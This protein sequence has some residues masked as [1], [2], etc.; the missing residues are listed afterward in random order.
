MAS[1][2]SKS[3]IKVSLEGDPKG[4]INAAT[5]AQHAINKLT[6]E[7]GVSRQEATAFVNNFDK[8]ER[9]K[10]FQQLQDSLKKNQTALAAAKQRARELAAEY[11]KTGDATAKLGAEGSRERVQRLSAEI[12]QQTTA[13]RTEGDALRKLGIDTKDLSGSQKKLTAEINKQEHNWKAAAEAVKRNAAMEKQAAE[14]RKLASA[15]TEKRIA[16]EKRYQEYVE[17]T[18][19]KLK[20][21]RSQTDKNSE[22]F[23][24]YKL[25]VVG[26]AAAFTATF[27]PLKQFVSYM[28]ENI[29]YANVQ[30]E[31]EAK[32][33][34]V[35][36]ATGNAAGLTA[37]EIKSYAGELQGLT[38]YGDEG[39]I[40][41]AALLATFKSIKGDQFKETIALAQDLSTIMGGDL[42]S[43]ALQLGKA[44]EDPV[45][46]LTALRRSGVSFTAEQKEQIAV[47]VETGRQQEAQAL[48]LA[49]VREQVGGAAA[50]MRD[51]YGGAVIA[52]GNAWGDLKEELGFFITKNDEAIRSVNFTEQA[53][54]GLAG[55]IK[56]FRENHE[57]LITSVIKF[58]REN[59]GLIAGVGAAGAA[60]TTA[61]VAISLY[62]TALVAS[63]VAS[64]QA[65]AA[66]AAPLAVI[67]GSVVT[68]GYAVKAYMEMR[69]AQE[70]AAES[71][72][73]AEEQEAKYQDRL[74]RASKAAGKQLKS[75]Q[76]VQEAYRQGVI[77]YDRLTD[78]YSK[79]S[80][81]AR[82]AAEDSKKA[83]EEQ[84]KVFEFTAISAEK[85]VDKTKLSAEEQ[86][87][88]LAE[89]KREYQSLVREIESVDQQLTK[90]ADEGAA[91]QLKLANASR[92]PLEAWKA[93]RQAAL[94]LG[95]AMAAAKKEADKLAA[96]GDIE[97][98]NK[99]YA[100]AVALGQQM[101]D[102][103]KELA[104]EVKGNFTPAMQQ[105]LDAAKEAAKD[106]G[107][108]YKKSMDEA[109]KAG[110]NLKSTTK[111]LADAQQ[112]LADAQRDQRRANMTDAQAYQDI[113]A[114]QRELEA[115]SKAAAEASRE[116]AGSGDYAAANVAIEKSIALA[117]E[118]RQVASELNQ[119][120]KEGEQVVV[121]A[122]QAKHNA[123]QAEI[124][125]RKLEIEALKIKAANEAQVE[126]EALA[127]AEKLKAA[128]EA[129]AAKVA[130][131]EAKKEEVVKTEAKAAQEAA[132][133]EADARKQITEILQ[134]QKDVLTELADQK[135]AEADWTLG[136]A[137]TQAGEDAKALFEVNQNIQQQLKDIPANAVI[138]WGSAWSQIKAA[139]VKSAETVEAKWDE[140]TRDRY[141]TTYVREVQQR[142]VGGFAGPVQGLAGGGQPRRLS[143]RYITGGAGGVDRFGPVMLDHREFV[144]QRGSVHAPE[145]GGDGLALAWAHNRQDWV[146]MHSLLSKHLGPPQIALDLPPVPAELS[147]SGRV[148][149][150]GGDERTLVFRD[151]ATKE[152]AKVTGS[153]FDLERLERQLKHRGVVSSR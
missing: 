49:V 129:E 130:E 115:A 139:G 97:G 70:M 62:N 7:L 148:D 47:L 10:G 122:E 86:K 72:K 141:I 53:I 93:Q 60:Y 11:R 45:T 94:D 12:R 137:Y 64:V 151:P 24:Q 153:S 119:E 110:D 88:Y 142:S 105:G 106:F 113:A 114:E 138:D 149:R 124:S 146:G 43:S 51:Q 67:A 52:A 15:A 135:N 152:E 33:E 101:R 126:F 48:I 99:S 80:G 75:Y 111:S 125:A 20:E 95:P 123:S 107:D 74:S 79:G 128:K 36:R 144:L 66:I 22:S 31:A 116:A 61:T 127:R 112:G 92:S 29:A 133:L 28:Q 42:R 8:L 27:V 3:N 16:D 71:G 87:K 134:A 136:D 140:A 58:V 39:T 56:E 55:K 69:D 26:L 150:R 145:L 90:L 37:D 40:A 21:L 30:E 108:Q 50:A 44:L 63:I 85:S 109:K 38:T 103:F 147:G 4:L 34:A 100:R 19:N 81:I 78:T 117:Q 84:Q 143:S 54:I 46:G 32:L 89:L 2:S 73:R 41:V 68:I 14:A 132:K 76:D 9:V 17:R 98:A 35:L 23:D 57:E 1:S 121:S 120:V 104:V 102:G 82:E 6:K 77:D 18:R 118:A 13:L 96:A 5:S 83:A 65:A 59:L 91:D 131:L 25:R